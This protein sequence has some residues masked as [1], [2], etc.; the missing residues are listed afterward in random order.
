MKTSVT[1]IPEMNR[2]LGN[3]LLDVMISYH[4]NLDIADVRRSWGG[5]Q[6]TASRTAEVKENQ[7]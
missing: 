5:P 4:T 6:Q 1:L 2:S 7:S 3:C